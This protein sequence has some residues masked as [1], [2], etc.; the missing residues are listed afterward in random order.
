LEEKKELRE[1]TLQRADD[2][3]GMAERLQAALI[4]VC[5]AAILR[6]KWHNRSVPWCMPEL[7]REKQRTYRARKRY[8]ATKDPT[9]RE[10]ERL[11]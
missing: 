2:V 8:Q 10:Q 6:K 5:N 1:T 7:T 9:T 11:R 3:E 4:R